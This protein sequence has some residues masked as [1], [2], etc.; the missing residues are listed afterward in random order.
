[1]SYWDQLAYATFELDVV[2]TTPRAKCLADFSLNPLFRRQWSSV[3]EAL[4]DARPEPEQLMQLYIKQMSPP[5]R[6]I[7]AVDHTL[8]SRPYART[9]K[10]RT[11]EHQPA[12]LPGHTPTCR[13]RFGLQHHCL[14]TRSSRKL[15]LTFTTRTHQRLGYTDRQSSIAAQASF[16]TLAPQ[17]LSLV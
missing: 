5:Q 14:D 7:L 17:T 8:W 4:Q 12:V 10:E 15:G 6:P 16:R 9:L 3:Y 2:M 13:G 1:M 11:Y